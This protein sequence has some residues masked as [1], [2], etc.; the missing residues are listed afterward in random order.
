MSTVG[1]KRMKKPIL[2]SCII[3][4]AMTTNAQQSDFQKLSGPY[5]G[6]KTPG[7][8]PELFAPVVLNSEV[9]YHSSIIFSPDLTEAYWS[10][11]ARE[12]NLYYSRIVNGTWSAPAVLYMGLKMGAHDARLSPDGKRLFFLSFE[13]D[14]P[15]GSEQER[16]WYSERVP[17][18]WSD[19]RL[20]DKSVYN[21]PTH[22][23]FSV[24]SNGNLYFT[25]EKMNY[26]GVCLSSYDGKNY[27]TPEKLFEGSMPHIAPDESYIVYV[28]KSEKT[29][30]DLFIRFKKSD[31]TWTDAIDMGL[32]VNSTAHDLAP[33]ISPDGKYM[34]FVSQRERMNGMM[35]MDARIIE[36]LRPAPVTMQA[37]EIF[38]AIKNNDLTKVKALVEKDSS[39]VNIKDVEGNAPLHIAARIGYIEQIEYLLIKGADKNLTNTQKNTPLIEA[40]IAEKTAAAEVLIL[41]G[42]N[43]NKGGILNLTPL[44]Y[45]VKSM[46]I[47]IVKLLLKNGADINV[48]S[49]AGATT[50]NYYCSNEKHYNILKC[51]I[52]NGADV[53]TVDNFG[54]SPLLRAASGAALKNIDLLLDSGAIIDTAYTKVI[55]ALNLA[56]ACGSKRLLDFSIKSLGARKIKSS[57]EEK[58]L[59]RK[60]LFGGSLEI[61]KLLREM[62]IPLSLEP[63]IRGITSL[64]TS[65]AM[66]NLELFEYLVNNG[67]DINLRTKSGKSAFNLAEENGNK[68]ISELIIKHG[69]STEPQRFPLLT[70][71]YLGQKPPEKSGETF[72]P[73]IVIP[74]HSTISVSPDGRELYWNSGP[75]FGDGPIMMTSLID[76]KWIKPVEAPFSGK[77]NSPWDDSPFVSPDNRKI[78]FISSRPYNDQPRK[79]NMWY[80]ERIESGWSEAKPVSNLVNSMKLHWGISVS[81]NGTLYF[82]SSDNENSG[83]FYSHLIDGEYTKPKFSGID[84]M[85]PYISPDESYMIFSRLI[86]NQTIPFICF[87][88]GNESWSVPIDIQ[89]YVPLGVCYSVTPDSKYVFIDSGI[90]ASA[91]FIEELRP[92]CQTTPNEFPVLNGPYLGQKPPGMTPEIFA[93]GIVSMPETSEWSSSFSSDGNEFYFQ[94]IVT[95]E[96]SVQVKIFGTKLIGNNWTQPAEVNFT[97]G[98]NAGAPHVTL[99]NKFLYFGW[100][101][102]NPEGDTD[103]IPGRVGR[104]WYVERTPIGWSEPRY[105]GQ[106]M[107]TSSDKKSYLYT[108]DLNSRYTN[109]RTYLAKTKLKNGQFSGFE[110]QIL[111]P[112]YAEPAH[113]CISQDGTYILFD[114]EGGSH[115]F[116]SFRKEDGSWGEAIDLAR[117]GF[118]VKAG[119]ATISPDGKY[120]FFH[121]NGDLWWV[122]I[123]TIEQLKPKLLSN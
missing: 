22:W 73:D 9:G 98:Y 81:M 43:L 85:S 51:L 64:H 115:L 106:G 90:W 97:K 7:M 62:D 114:I 41:K 49:T 19:A 38:D 82:N 70:G 37:Q 2:I 12:N 71:P 66:N 118:D 52:E 121:L 88:S 33:Y 69:G 26:E 89:K 28:I 36:E 95:Y 119:G 87:K 3:A 48:K 76:G 93:P 15:G 86:S 94:R 99:D 25:S 108:T 11:M 80:V 122:D 58:I 61:V 101:R 14:K 105:A 6:Q 54:T 32:K 46:K 18:G 23:T 123:K 77:K 1:L 35:W 34:F 91:S 16:I 112:N 79:E 96:D 57:E 47:D 55:Q 116:V 78:Y 13:P 100:W 109:G 113:P 120:L 53:N 84:G 24:A 92:V 31:G 102:P 75:T 50:L 21:H 44:W 67:A 63:N 104:I 30:T 60:A 45:A 103:F 74:N 40:V 20:I 56:A 4:I 59:M 39:L 8:I 72:A 10:D 27:Q 111:I 65:A 117:H 5:L 17:G 42:A 83:V 68:E 107:F 29:K 110:K